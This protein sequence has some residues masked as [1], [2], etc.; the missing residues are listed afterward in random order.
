MEVFMIVSERTTTA[1]KIGSVVLENK[2]MEPTPC[3]KS[4]KIESKTTMT[5][6]TIAQIKT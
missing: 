3:A 4:A 5:K 1:T 2:F 6:V